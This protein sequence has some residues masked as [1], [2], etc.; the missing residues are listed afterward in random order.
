[1][2]ACENDCAQRTRCHHNERFGHESHAARVTSVGS[3]WSRCSLACI[4]C[5]TEGTS[6]GDSST[7]ARR[8]LGLTRAVIANPRV[9]AQQELFRTPT[10]AQTLVMLRGCAEHA[11]TVAIVVATVATLCDS[12]YAVTAC[13]L[14]SSRTLLC[15]HRFGNVHR[16]YFFVYAPYTTHV[17][18]TAAHAYAHTT[19]RRCPSV[20][21]QTSH[22][23]SACR[24]SLPCLPPPNPPPPNPSPPNPR[25]PTPRLLNPRHA[26]SHLANH[27]PQTHIPQTTIHKLTS[28]KPQSASPRPQPLQ[29]GPTFSSC[30]LY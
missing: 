20:K 27:N 21:A 22:L 10:S 2:R 17:L 29:P 1:M 25:S 19:D 23:T 30:N 13:T 9:T 14:A 28:R 5:S 16:P 6:T 8:C 7:L 26:N 4:L 18:Y 12:R 15:L 11:A 24:P 3:P